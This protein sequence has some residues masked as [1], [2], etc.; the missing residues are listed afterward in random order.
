MMCR[1]YTSTLKA[2]G[3]ENNKWLEA[4]ITYIL[5][6]LNNSTTVSRPSTTT[7]TPNYENTDFCSIEYADFT[8]KTTAASCF[9][10]H[11]SSVPAF[12]TVPGS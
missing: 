12:K 6:E 3:H 10:I 9:H 7:S 11:L 5:M 2:N 1:I 8:K 4:S